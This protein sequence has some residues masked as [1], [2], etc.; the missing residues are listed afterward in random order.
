MPQDTSDL[1]ADAE[2][3]FT[4]HEAFV[5]LA[6]ALFAVATSAVAASVWLLFVPVS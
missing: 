5:S 2:R 6:L 3:H 4:L 1:I